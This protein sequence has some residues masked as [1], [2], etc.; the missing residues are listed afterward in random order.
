MGPERRIRWSLG[1]MLRRLLLL[2][3]EAVGITAE[4]SFP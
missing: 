1:S 3:D 2:G 4:K